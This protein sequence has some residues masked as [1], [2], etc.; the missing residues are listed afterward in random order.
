MRTIVYT[1]TYETS[2]LY[3]HSLTVTFTTQKPALSLCTPI[4]SEEKFHNKRW[5]KR[6]KRKAVIRLIYLTAGLSQGIYLMGSTYIM[7]E[8]RDRK[9]LGRNSFFAI[10]FGAHHPSA[11]AGDS[12]VSQVHN[13][14]LPIIPQSLH[15][16]QLATVSNSQ[17]CGTVKWWWYAVHWQTHKTYQI[18]I[19]EFNQ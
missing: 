10:F 1:I 16:C 15:C 19:Y 7:I 11:P 12:H 3:W 9:T 17:Y 18:D 14:S 13:L 6:K 4:E 5:N 8:R 2:S